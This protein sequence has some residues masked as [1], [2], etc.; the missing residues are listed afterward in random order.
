MAL[1]N[2]LV[3]EGKLVAEVE[4][5]AQKMIETSPSDLWNDDE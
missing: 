3:A 4:R 1:E 2:Q 5:L